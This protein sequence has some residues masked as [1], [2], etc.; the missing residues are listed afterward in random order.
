MTKKHEMPL[1]GIMEV[2]IFNV[3][4]IYFMGPFPLSSGCKYIL[5][6]V[7]YVSKWV[8]AIAFPTNDA[9][10]L[11]N[12]LAQYGVKHKVAT[13]YNPQTSGQVKISNRVIKQILEKTISAS[14]K[15]WDAK[16][17]D[18][19][20][21]Y[22]TAYKTPIGFSPYKLVYGKDYKH[23]RKSHWKCAKAS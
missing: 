8:G 12:V 6:A 1:H 15:D 11:D 2:E 13:A 20:W 9:K 23:R 10:I 17:D 7:D 16:L 4:G 18:A 14:R 3:R 22:R 19:L 5:V 21:A